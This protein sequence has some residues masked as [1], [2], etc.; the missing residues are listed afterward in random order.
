M[1]NAILLAAVVTASPLS[2]HSAAKLRDLPF[3]VV[4]AH[5]HLISTSNGIDYL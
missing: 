4:D 5:V 3:K 2:H 1:M